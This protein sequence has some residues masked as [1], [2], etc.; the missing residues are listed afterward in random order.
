MTI[1]RSLS[2]A[3]GVALAFGAAAAQPAPAP[4]SGSGSGVSEKAGTNESLQNGG[5]ERPWAAGVKPAEQQIALQMFHDAN[6]ELNNGLFAKAS[7]KYLDALKHWDHPA[8]HYN[9]ALAEMNLDQPIEAS[10]NLQVAIRYGE[11][12]LQSK[13]KF[14][15]A[16]EY[17]R[18]LDKQIAEV[19]VTCNK[20][21]AKVSIDSKQVFVAPG[22]YKGKVRA[23][24][25]TFVA[26]LEGHPTRIDAPYISPG[27]PFRIELKLYTV[28]ELTRY[29]R[30]WQ[31]TWM[32]YVVIGSGVLVGVIAGFVE[33]AASNDYKSY[34]D[35]VAACNTNNAG[36]PNTSSLTDLRNSGDTKKTVGFVGYGLAG[37]TIVV[38][39]ALAW[40][41]RP[42]AYQL[43]SEDLT[44]E[45][46]TIAPMVAPGLAGASVQGRF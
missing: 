28:A 39:A 23:G 31:A 36:C 5:D 4:D 38:G 40:I 41:N 22:S 25:H 8:I 27:A 16:K 10:A 29:H 35:K 14:D 13:D 18:L 15:S 43:R 33:L 24:K 46:V 1:G 11:A 42:E 44:D 9:L 30:K 26:E 37:A 20:T 6:V 7:D 21:G 2:V 17:L 12:P 34:D 45:K 32:P 3:F 19:E